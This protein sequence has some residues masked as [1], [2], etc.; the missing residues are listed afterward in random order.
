LLELI[1]HYSR[2]LVTPVTFNTPN[3]KDFGNQLVRKSVIIGITR[4]H[5]RHEF[6]RAFFYDPPKDVVSEGVFPMRTIKAFSKA[7]DHLILLF[8]SH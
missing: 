5:E 4:H 8:M 1:K 7:Y 2:K 6:T 3:K